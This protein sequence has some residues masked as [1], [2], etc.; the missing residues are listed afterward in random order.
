MSYF[1]LLY[2]TLKSII[3]FVWLFCFASEFDISASLASVKAPGFVSVLGFDGSPSSVGVG[4]VGFA[5]VLLSSDFSTGD[6]HR[7]KG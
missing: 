1:R 5:S 4:L 7:N 2:T 6:I 3:S